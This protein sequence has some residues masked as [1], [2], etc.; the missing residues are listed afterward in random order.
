MILLAECS[1]IRNYR[2]MMKYYISDLHFFHEKLNR[3]MDKRGFESVEEMHMHMLRQWN[4]KVNRRDEVFILGDV[5][6]GNAEEINEIL[7]K[8]NGKLYL[9]KGNHDNRFLR[10]TA[11]DDTRFEWIKDY[12]EISDNNRKII[13]C[14]YPIMC[15]NGQYKL[16]ADGKPKVYMLYGHV[17]DTQDQRLME[18]FIKITRETIHIRDGI[19]RR[20]P[21]NMLNCFCLYSD[22]VP[23][24]LDEWINFWR[25]RGV[26][27]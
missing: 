22:Y 1:D 5:G 6:F 19:E 7:K 11:F 23:W 27:E 10:K 4:S 25:E 21:C 24:S 15:Y 20:I 18:E 8:L 12:A 9:I 3:E 17:H 14:H 26:I 16:T 13:L 2:W